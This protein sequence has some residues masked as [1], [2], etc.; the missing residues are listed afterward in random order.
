M[1]GVMLNFLMLDLYTSWMGTYFGCCMPPL[2]RYTYNYILICARNDEN[3]SNSKFWLMY[4]LRF[5]IENE[6]GTGFHE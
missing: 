5:H 1:L 6:F 2:K 4:H 3:F